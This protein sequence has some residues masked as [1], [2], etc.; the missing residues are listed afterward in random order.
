MVAIPRRVQPQFPPE[1]LRD[2]S[3]LQCTEMSQSPGGPL[4]DA[5]TLAFRK[6]MSQSPE[7]FSLNFHE[8]MQ[9]WHDRV[10]DRVSQSPAGSSLNLHTST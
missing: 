2:E 8:V 1:V 9:R 6:V 10:C 7:G 3:D 5:G 4:N